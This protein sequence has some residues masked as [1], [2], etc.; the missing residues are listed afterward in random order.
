MREQANFADALKSNTTRNAA[1]SSDEDALLLLESGFVQRVRRL[2]VPFF[3]KHEDI[4]A[5]R[6]PIHYIQGVSKDELSLCSDDCLWKVIWE[7]NTYDL[8]QVHKESYR[9][10]IPLGMG[11]LFEQSES[12]AGFMKSPPL[13]VGEAILFY[14]VLS[15]TRLLP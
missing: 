9:L 8:P 13:A 10:R 14:Q 5:R 2:Y 3:V 11:S 12:D 4:V 7:Q 15:E 6:Y 1:H